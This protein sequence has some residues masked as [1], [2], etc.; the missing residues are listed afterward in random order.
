MMEIADIF[1]RY[2]PQYRQKFGQHMPV[3]HHQ[4]M[5]AI[6]QCRTETLGGHVFHC[7]DCDETLYSYH[8]CKNRHCPKCQND[9]AEQWLQK[10]QALLLPG[11]HFLV[12]FTLPAQLRPVARRQQK[13]VYNILFRTSAA[14]LQQLA[15]DPRFVGGTVGMVGVLHTWT[16]EL[17]YHPHIHYLVPAGGLAADGQR[18]LP[19]RKEFLVH[20][21]PLSILFRAKVRD[22]LKKI[23]CF[24]QVSPETWTTDWVV[25]CKS[26]GNGTAA[27]KYLAP[28]VFRVAISNNRLVSLADDKVTFRYKDANSGQTRYRTLP[29][30]EFIRRFLQHVLPK[31]FVKVRYYGLFSPSYRPLLSQAKQLLTDRFAPQ[32]TQLDQAPSEAEPQPVTKPP[33]FSLPCPTCGRPMAAVETIKAKRCRS[34]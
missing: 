23:P 1:R 28:Y 10:Q 31:G 30:E 17:N 5:L 9:T 11:P 19:S 20:V 6:E 25:H 32:P 14:A 16:R 15:A 27:L 26:V 24:D 8:S 13:T 34:P 3:S 22:E 21:K 7:E 4:A 2:G 29:V 18:W 12:T 33:D